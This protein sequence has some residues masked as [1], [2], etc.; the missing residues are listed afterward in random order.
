MQFIVTD[1]SSLIIGKNM[2]RNK[3]PNP[4]HHKVPT[5][6]HSRSNPTLQNAIKVRAA[7]LHSG[8]QG[9]AYNTINS[10]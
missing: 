8:N 3:L 10:S 5:G 2:Y 9:P 1:I 6:V 4:W 7:L